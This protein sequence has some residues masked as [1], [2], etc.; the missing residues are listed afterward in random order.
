MKKKELVTKDETLIEVERVKRQYDKASH[1]ESLMKEKENA[2]REEE[3]EKSKYI[4][5]QM[6]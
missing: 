4:T 2:M 1:E 5:D 3:L 6:Q